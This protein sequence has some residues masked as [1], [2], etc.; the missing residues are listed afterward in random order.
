MY[1]DTNNIEKILGAR[2]TFHYSYI[3]FLNIV[4]SPIFRIPSWGCWLWRSFRNNLYSPNCSNSRYSISQCFVTLLWPSP[5]LVSND[6]YSSRNVFLTRHLSQH[7]FVQ[8]FWV[9]RYPSR[10]CHRTLSYWHLQNTLHLD[11]QSWPWLGKITVPHIP[12]AGSWFLVTCVSTPLLSD[13]S[14][15]WCLFVGQLWHGRAWPVF[16]SCWQLTRECSTFYSFCSTTLSNLHL[17]WQGPIMILLSCAWK[18]KR[19]GKDF[20][21][22]RWKK[23]LRFQLNWDKVV[24]T[25][26]PKE[27]VSS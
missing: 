26:Y 16:L 14:C 13:V 10:Q 4:C 25:F 20:W 22:T 18:M 24:S 1:T 3:L 8:L 15:N 27:N 17:V 7:I 19:R 9:E 5:G 2:Q 23:R 11:H 6:Q 12:P 21:R